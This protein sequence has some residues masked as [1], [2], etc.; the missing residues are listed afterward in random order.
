M[1]KTIM[2]GLKI[3]MINGPSSAGFTVKKIPDSVQSE[4]TNWQINSKRAFAAFAALALV[5]SLTGNNLVFANPPPSPTPTPPSIQV[6]KING[7]SSPFNFV[8]PT[9]PLFNP[10]N[11]TGSGAGSV[12]PGKV[13]QY[14]VQ[15]DW[16]DGVIQDS[17]T[18][19]T[20]IVASFTPS[21]GNQTNFTFTFSAG[22]HTYTSDGN[23]A[24]V[25]SL[26]HQNPNG[27]DN[28]NT[29]DQS[30]SV[31]NNCVITHYATLHVV[32]HIGGSVGGAPA[33]SFNLHVKTG[34]ADITGSPAAGAEAPGTP[35]TVVAGTVYTVSEG[36]PL[37]AGYTQTSIMCDGVATD[38]ITLAT[39]DDKTCTITNTFNP[40]PSQNNT[41]SVTTAGTGTGTVSSTPGSI[42]C[43]DNAGTCSGSFASGTSVTLTAT[44]DSGSNFTSWG[45]ACSGS[46]TCSVTMSTAKSVTATFT[47]N[48]PTTGTLTVYKQVVNDNGGTKNP[49]D[50]TMH[51]SDNAAVS[52]TFPGS[53]TGTVTTLAGGTY[54]VFD[55][56]LPNYYGDLSQCGNQGMVTV[57][58]GQ[59]TSCTITNNDQPAQIR[60]IKHVVND[61]GGTATADQFTISASGTNVSLTSFP[62]S[63]TGTV[64]SLNAGSYSIDESVMVAGYAKS[65][66]PDCSGTIGI[67]ENRICTITNDDNQPKLTVT[68]VVENGNNANPLQV[69]DFPLSVSSTTVVSGVQHGFNAGNYQVTEINPDSNYTGAF[70]GDCDSQGGITLNLGDAKICTLTNTYHAPQPPPPAH[71]TV[72]KTVV[73]NHGGTKA[74]GDFTINVSGNSV[75]SSTFPGDELGTTVTLNAGSYSVT[76][77]AVAGY[78]GNLS[79]AC[80]GTAASGNSI[81]CTIT[82]SDQAAHLTVVKNVINNDGGTKTAAD[83]TISVTG[84]NATPPSFVGDASGT[85]VTLD[86]GEY[87]VTENT[88]SVYAKSLSADCSGT[89]GIGESKTCTITNDDISQGG[90][91]G[92]GGGG[93]FAVNVNKLGSGTGTVTSLVSGIDCGSTC[94]G[95]AASGSAET[96]TAAAGSASEF[97][98]WGGACSS[99]GTSTVCTLTITSAT[100]VTAT[101]N[102]V[103]GGSAPI[104]LTLTK[105]GDGNGT[106]TGS[107][108]GATSTKFCDLN[109][110]QQ[111]NEKQSFVQTYA[112]GTVI[113]L[114]ANPDSNSN[115]NGTW[116]SGPCASSSNPVCTF[117]MTG[118]VLVNAHFGA[119]PV[120]PPGGGSTSS[121][122]SF[123][124]GSSYYAAT[125]PVPQVLGAT[126]GPSLEMPAQTGQV[127]GEATTLPRTGMPIGFTL[128]VFGAA[129][130]LLDK[131]FKLV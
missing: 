14:G 39:N 101:F 51:I 124:G 57:T 45:G 129:L 125:P 86:A 104:V 13:E 97:A 49:S 25:A 80:S 88:D 126:T 114:T 18:N 108:D 74:A 110:C 6:D 75:S 19:P 37:P 66:S 94:S 42:L 105:T 69:S 58:N 21:S 32:K 78:S 8:C 112:S 7:Q 12:P 118:P 116:T 56:T 96:L 23:I 63:E 41:L 16:G 113:T 59:N 30:F 11:L 28:Q 128:L 67:G 130:A 111:S 40:A 72:V 102:T 107:V 91:G 92:G 55:D 60:V 48:P 71:L 77:D 22:P 26:F 87:N 123:S 29:I 90:G 4:H 95:S 119:N 20:D 106:V 99:F 31:T 121:G 68:K 127:L 44:P 61:N 120:T 76:E 38:T 36:L 3:T 79:Q 62:G 89:I 27:N 43:N 5:F 83:F 34:G 47:V 85:I 100:D 53:S 93:S 54:Y 64:I 35:Y 131:K 15:I 65:L 2:K 24:I 117:T 98:G 9:N 115:F 70:S 50:F 1:K 46:G 33:S 81:T 103:G 10:I 73:N 109:E 84:V 17:K 82:N 52:I 122:S